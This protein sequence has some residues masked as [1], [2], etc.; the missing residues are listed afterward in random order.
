[1]RA[2]YLSFICFF[3][4]NFLLAESPW[5]MDADLALDKKSRTPSQEV[6][7]I[8]IALIRAYQTYISP[9]NGPRSS[10][11]PTSSMYTLHAI[12]RY[13]FFWGYLYGCDR[14]IREN[15]DQWIYAHCYQ[16]GGFYVKWDPVP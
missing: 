14:L 4:L 10:Y 3:S 12:Q 8:S 13:G 5:G 1:M 11:L 16:P 6:E 7:S 9:A 15:D 2:V